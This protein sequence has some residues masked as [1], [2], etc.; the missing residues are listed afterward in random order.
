MRR[1]QLWFAAVDLRRLSTGDPS[2]AP[3]WLP[4]QEVDQSNHIPLWTE[5][6]GCITDADCGPGSVCKTPD[7]KATGQC[8]NIIV[9]Q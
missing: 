5:V 1:A 3:L 9:I 6:I 7:P 8:N 4:F 2:W